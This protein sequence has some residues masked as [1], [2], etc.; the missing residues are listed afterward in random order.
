MCS[1]DG[2]YKN[3]KQIAKKYLF[4]A[5]G[6][7]VHI[8]CKEIHEKY[9]DHR[10]PT[11]AKYLANPIS[12]IKFHYGQIYRLIGL[13]RKFFRLMVISGAERL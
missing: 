7:Q 5:R 8:A 10:P 6:L 9:I 3:N 12:Q 11:P 1:Q 4:L 13:F 2:P